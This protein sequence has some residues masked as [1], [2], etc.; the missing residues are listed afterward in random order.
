MIPTLL[1]RRDLPALLLPLLGAGCKHAPAAARENANDWETA[2][3]EEAGFQS[4]AFEALTANIKAGKFPN[5]HAVLIER[6]GSLVYEQYFAGSDE[7]WG[8]SLGHRTFDAAALHDL[9]SMSKSVTSALVGIALAKDFDKALARP[10]RSFFPNRQL[11]PELDALTLHH[12]LTMTSGLE[13]NEMTVPYTNAKNDEIQMSS[14]KDPVGLV[15]ARPLREKPGERWYYNGGLTQVLAG[16][17]TQ[18]TGRPFEA[19]AREALFTPLGIT[20]L[21][22]IGH[23]NWDPPMP[24]TASGLRLRAR[25][26]ARFGSVYLHG[27][28]WRGRQIVPAAWVER[29]IQ[30]HV[31]SIGDWSGDAKWGY[32]YQWWVGRPA[33]FDAAAAVGNGNQRIFLVPAE[34]LAISVFA[35]EYN[36]FEGHSERIFASVM[37]AR[38]P[39]A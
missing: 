25:D 5:T 10:I 35:G 15:L 39:R 31:P 38:A 19:F 26:L 4:A 23:P 3:P 22:W 29:S 37:A 30:R 20:Q 13:W 16:L 18:I 27:G 17:V 33:G 1:R 14:V 8:S 12:V 6:D 2:R 36:K 32:G 24:A 21:E 11:R 34:R 28:Q 9:R 7:R